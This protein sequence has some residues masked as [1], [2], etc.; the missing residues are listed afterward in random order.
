MKIKITINILDIAF[1]VMAILKLL[2]KINWHWYVI[3]LPLIVK[4]IVAFIVATIVVITV[5]LLRRAKIL[6]F[7]QNDIL[8]C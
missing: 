4:I 6:R 5:A 7:A 2:D 8:V 1:V 3:L